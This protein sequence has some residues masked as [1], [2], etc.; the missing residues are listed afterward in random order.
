MLEEAVREKKGGAPP[1]PEVRVSL[2]M[3]VDFQLPEEFVSEPHQRLV[4]YKRVAAAAEDGQLERVREEIEDRYGHLPREAENLLNL[5]ALR[6]QAERLGIA[7]VEAKGGR[8]GLHFVDGAPLDPASLLEWV[9]FRQD[10][11]LAPSGLLEVPVPVDPD[12]R[13]RETVEIVQDL[14]R[15]VPDPSPAS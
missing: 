9:R 2:E 5:A 6:S 7:T 4:L 12:E 14:A 1:L 10:T 3:G 11:T 15:L 8:V 13:L